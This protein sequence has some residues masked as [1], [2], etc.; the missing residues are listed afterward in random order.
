L[1]IFPEGEAPIYING[2]ASLQRYFNV[3]GHARKVSINSYGEA[4]RN[5]VKIIA[6]PKDFVI[7][8]GLDQYALGP[9]REPSRANAGRKKPYSPSKPGTDEN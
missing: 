6:V 8:Y 4:T 2:I 1:L 9:T 3:D 5:N 7:K